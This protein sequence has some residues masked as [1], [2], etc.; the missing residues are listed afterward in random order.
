VMKQAKAR[1]CCLWF[2][3][4]GDFVHEDLK[5]WDAMLILSKKM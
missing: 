2:S 3:D 5:I 4:D 1:L